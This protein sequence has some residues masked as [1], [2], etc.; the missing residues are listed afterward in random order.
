MAD[1]Y[2]TTPD[3]VPGPMPGVLFIV[4]AIGLRPQTKAMADR[5]AS[6]GYVVLAPNV[7]YRDGTAPTLEPVGDLT[8]PENRATFMSEAMSRVKAL[9][10][11]LAERDLSVYIDTLRGRDDVRQ[12]DIGVTGYCMGG[13]LALLVAAT[14]PDSVGAIGMFHTGGLVTDNPD[15]P[16]RL[17]PKIRADVLAIHADQDRSLPPEAVAEFEHALTSCGVSHSAWVHEGAHH[18][19][20]MADTAVYHPAAAEEHFERLDELFTRTLR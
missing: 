17:L 11:D 6:W 16:H 1:A 20:T 19:F 18:G 10:N 5:I 4:D 7:F 15:S 3:D 2:V 13:R 14:R 12:G 9:T 8:E